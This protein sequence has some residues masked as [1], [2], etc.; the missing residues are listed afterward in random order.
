MQVLVHTCRMCT[1]ELPECQGNREELALSPVIQVTAGHNIGANQQ[2]SP[3][4]IS[5]RLTLT[6][7][8]DHGSQHSRLAQSTHP[9]VLCCQWNEGC[10]LDTCCLHQGPGP[11]LY[12]VSQGGL[13]SLRQ[14]SSAGLVSL[15]SH[16]SCGGV[17]LLTD[18]KHK[19]GEQAK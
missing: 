8:C 3:R 1:L 2:G 4:G 10:I 16:S 11:N 18:R 19:R 9:Q 5:S 6:T 7:L 13:C 15:T 14:R 12:A 17:K